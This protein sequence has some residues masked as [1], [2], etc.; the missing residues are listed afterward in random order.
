[1]PMRRLMTPMEEEEENNY[2]IDELGKSN[3]ERKYGDPDGAN[4][5]NAEA[6]YMKDGDSGDADT[7][8]PNSDNVNGS[9]DDITKTNDSGADNLEASDS[10][11]SDADSNAADDADTDNAVAIPNSKYGVIDDIYYNDDGTDTKKLTLMTLVI[12]TLS[13]T[14]FAVWCVPVLPFSN[15]LGELG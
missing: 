3:T 5:D 12:Q 7:D 6:V 9:D 4:A 14:C 13:M 1:M 10:Y 11:I 15:E 8:G 2:D